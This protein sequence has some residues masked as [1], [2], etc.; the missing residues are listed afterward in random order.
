MKK[1]E[2]YT[3]KQISDYLIDKIAAERGISKKLARQ[4]F[5]NAIAYNVVVAAINEQIDFLID[6]EEDEEVDAILQRVA[7]HQ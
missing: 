2:T 6:Y 4:L 7:E 3:L 5:T 1:L